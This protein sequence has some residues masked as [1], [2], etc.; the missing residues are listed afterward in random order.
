MVSGADAIGVRGRRWDDDRREVGH[1]LLE[2]LELIERPGRRRA[3]MDAEG[4]R[5]VLLDLRVRIRRVLRRDVLRLELDPVGRGDPLEDGAGPIEL[6]LIC[7]LHLVGVGIR[8]IERLRLAEVRLALDARARVLLLRDVGELVV[9]QL[10]AIG[11][12]GPV[13]AGREADVVAM[14]ERARAEPL[15]R[16]RGVG[17]VVNAHVR[18]IQ[19]RPGS[20]RRIGLALG[21]GAR[22]DRVR[23]ARASGASARPRDASGGRAT[24][25]PVSRRNSTLACCRTALLSHCRAAKGRRSEPRRHLPAGALDRS[26]GCASRPAGVVA[27]CVSVVLAMAMEVTSHAGTGSLAGGVRDETDGEAGSG[28]AR[29]PGR[30]GGVRDGQAAR[31]MWRPGQS[32]TATPLPH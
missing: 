22:R 5:R 3:A 23:P 25:R 2:L 21:L 30:S 19:A 17:V 7:H 26:A 16:P 14:G 20:W 28:A 31:S 10:A 9:Q 15:C 24:R 11:G 27:A 18:E 32:T 29:A 4:Q 6:P 8:R 12:V 1:G 13:R